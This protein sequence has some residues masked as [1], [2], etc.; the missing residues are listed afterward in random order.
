[1]STHNICFRGEIRKILCEYTVLT[2]A[3]TSCNPVFWEH[4]H[5]VI[6][7]MTL[8]TP[9]FCMTLCNPVFWEHL[10]EVI[11]SNRSCYCSNNVQISTV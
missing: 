5:E 7:R 6:Q 11:Q 1:M 2:G 9:V 10:Y 3:M 8:C 4:Q